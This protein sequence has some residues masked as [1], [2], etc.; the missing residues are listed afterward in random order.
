MTRNQLQSAM[1][2]LHTNTLANTPL[3]IYQPSESYT[4]GAGFGVAYPD[5]PDTTLP[6]RIETPNSAPERERSGTTVAADVVVRVRDDTDITWT[7]YGE[8]G[9]ASVRVAPDDAGWGVQA[10]G[11]TAWGAPTPVYEIEDVIDG[12]NGLLRLPATEV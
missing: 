5:S 4:A 6:G 2:R 11:T 9:D 7:G 8:S 3:A 12:Q 1:R 10:W